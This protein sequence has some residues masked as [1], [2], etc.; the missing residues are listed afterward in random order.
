MKFKDE[1]PINFEIFQSDMEKIMR[2]LDDVIR[3]PDGLI[4]TKYNATKIK[5][6]FQ[7]KIEIHREEGDWV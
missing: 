5:H 3:D 6:D 4:S 1:S 2:F 7:N